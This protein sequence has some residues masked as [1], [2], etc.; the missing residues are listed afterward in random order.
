LM[1]IDYIDLIRNYFVCCIDTQE[2]D[3]GHQK[4]VY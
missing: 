2:T 3:C 1:P 4:Y